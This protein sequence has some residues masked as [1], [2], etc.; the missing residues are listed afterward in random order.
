MRIECPKDTRQIRLYEIPYDEENVTPIS[1]YHLSNSISFSEL[2]ELCT[3]VIVLFVISSCRNRFRV[4][5]RLDFEGTAY[6]PTISV[7]G[8]ATV[9]ISTND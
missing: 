8:I 1:L 9:N 3:Q 6:L 5:R 2:C 4:V 7:K